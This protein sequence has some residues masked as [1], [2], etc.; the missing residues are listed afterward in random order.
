MIVLIPLGPAP[1][2]LISSRVLIWILYLGFHPNDDDEAIVFQWEIRNRNRQGRTLL[3]SPSLVSKVILILAVASLATFSFLFFLTTVRCC[4]SSSGTSDLRLPALVSPGPTR[5]FCRFWALIHRGLGS[6][7][8]LE[9]EGASCC[10]SESEAL[11]RFPMP[12]LAERRGGVEVRAI[13]R[14]KPVNKQDPCPKKLELTPV[15]IRSSCVDRSPLNKSKRRRLW[16]ARKR[17]GFLSRLAFP[18]N[19]GYH[20]QT[21]KAVQSI[22]LQATVYNRYIHIH[23]DTGRSASPL[24]RVN[25]HSVVPFPMTT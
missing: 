16:V 19:N 12:N 13:C 24:T 17:R 9:E 4:C 1:L 7:D 25:F 6:D 8:N 2:T 11:A 22:K 18:Q 23:K 15:R 21:N 20:V 5:I 3:P 14:T 10:C